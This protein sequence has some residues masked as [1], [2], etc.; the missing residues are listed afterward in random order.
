MVNWE[1]MRV[2]GSGE[3]KLRVRRRTAPVSGE[4]VRGSYS[5]F[6]H[7]VFVGG[8]DEFRTELSLSDG[9]EWWLEFTLC[10]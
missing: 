2:W 10:V 3:G 6:R 4:V 1:S 5:A 9:K 8:H 7:L